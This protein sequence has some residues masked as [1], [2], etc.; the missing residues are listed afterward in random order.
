[1]PDINFRNAFEFVLGFIP[2]FLALALVRSIT[3]LQLT[4]FEFAYLG[5][6]LSIPILLLVRVFSS[7]FE[8]RCD[9]DTESQV[10]KSV[11]LKLVF[12]L[13]LIILTAFFVAKIVED[14]LMT[15]GMRKI[16]GKDFPMLSRHDLF[17]FLLKHREDCTLS[18]VSPR[19]SIYVNGCK[20]QLPESH[21]P[22]VVV[23]GASTGIYEGYP[24]F[25]SSNSDN[26]PKIYLAPAC[27]VSV[28][29]TLALHE[30]IKGNGVLITDIAKMEFVDIGESAC[31]AFYNK[32]TNDAI[33]GAKCSTHSDSSNGIQD[34]SFTVLSLS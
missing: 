11:F 24:R 26:N 22:W 29:N 23:Q 32:T 4:D 27:K 8:K 9:G 19:E 5:I 21:K 13:P 25:Y 34:K 17:Y 14:D 28:S 18:D 2:G 1:M 12:L 15:K 10:N 3:E 6:A 31:A 33:S 7:V 20:Q 30:P 16:A